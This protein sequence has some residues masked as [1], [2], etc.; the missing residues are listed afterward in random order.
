MKDKKIEEIF[1]EKLKETQKRGIWEL[2]KSFN[3]Y[4]SNGA[5]ICC[6]ITFVEYV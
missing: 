5:Y 4:N 1:E 2:E 6:C 3:N